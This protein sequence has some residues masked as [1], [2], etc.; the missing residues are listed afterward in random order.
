MGQKVNPIGLRVAVNRG[1]ESRW[2]AEGKEYAKWLNQDI[3]IRDLLFRELKKSA[4]A[5]IEIERT[6]EDI[7]LF[8]KTARPG[9]VLG[10]SGKNLEVITKKIHQAIKDRKIKIKINVLEIKKPELDAQLVA[11][12]IAHQI[13]NRASFRTVQKFAIKKARRAGALGI[14]TLV[15]GRLNGVDMARTEGYLEGSVPLATLRSNIDY[16]KAEADTTY[17]K[18]GVKVW[19]YKGE[20]LPGTRSVEDNIVDRK[21]KKKEFVRKPFVKRTS[22]SNNNYNNRTTN[23]NANKKMGVK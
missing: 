18:I 15:S 20:V 9:M 8:I 7:T 17:G 3:I 19:I 13:S 21:F 11:D 14:K 6:K 22:S 23:D 10:D 1:W 4:V 16:A 2:F 12:N 5:R